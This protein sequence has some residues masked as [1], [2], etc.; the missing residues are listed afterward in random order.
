MEHRSYRK[1]WR[2]ECHSRV[3]S[4][5]C[6]SWCQR[7]GGARPDLWKQEPL[8]CSTAALEKSREWQRLAFGGD[9]SRRSAL[10]ARF[11]KER[12]IPLWGELNFGFRHHVSEK[13]RRCPALSRSRR[14]LFIHPHGTTERDVKVGAADQLLLLTT[15]A[16]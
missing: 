15:A 3:S 5:E 12:K 13:L 16:S 14:V 4:W 11:Q 1:R 7:C 9:P 8:H 2:E 6:W 10:Q